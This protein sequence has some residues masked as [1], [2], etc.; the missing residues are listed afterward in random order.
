MKRIYFVIFT[1][2]V[3]LFI[4][5]GLTIR[6]ESISHFSNLLFILGGLTP[7]ILS[8]FMEKNKTL[9]K[10]DSLLII[11]IIFI[12]FSIFSSL[13]NQDLNSFKS[14]L[15]LLVLY[16]FTVVVVYN[17][18][19]LLHPK[20]LI[21]Y[22]LIAFILISFYSIIEEPIDNLLIVYSGVFDNSNSLG[23]LG[24]TMV[25]VSIIAIQQKSGIFQYVSISILAL[26]LFFIILSGSR[27]AFLT[28]LGLVLILISYYIYTLLIKSKIKQFKFRYVA[29]GLSIIF[30]II[31][32]I[33]NDEVNVALDNNIIEKFNRKSGDITSS[34][35]EIWEIIISD[36]G[37]I[38]KGS[39]YIRDKIGLAA[40]NSFLSIMIEYGWLS[41]GIYMFFWLMVMIK[42][43]KI[44]FNNRDLLPVMLVSNFILLSTMEVL[45]VH[46][47][48][49]LAMFAIGYLYREEYHVKVKVGK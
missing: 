45:T 15:K 19:A 21:N 12:L 41:G 46:S 13:I 24:A 10:I 30:I 43:F 1:I 6:I 4:I 16:L 29:I 9:F 18:Q 8:I 22:S 28:V 5:S 26:S 39:S 38:G 47:S 37:F 17:N 2:S 11:Y 35:T 34:R 40:H 32:G 36:A 27:T 23:M 14:I 25:A 33:N 20:R 49:L 7:L 48:A 31:I 42:S 44:S 3:V